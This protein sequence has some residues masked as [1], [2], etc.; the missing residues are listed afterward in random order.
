[1]I[2]IFTIS[3]PCYKNFLSLPIDLFYHLTHAWKK[4][5]I[6]KHNKLIPFRK[7]SRIENNEKYENTVG[8]L[9]AVYRVRNLYVK[10]RVINTLNIL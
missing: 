6:L 7:I 8:K 4:A 1:M 3:P 2:K 10:R 9:H 5:L